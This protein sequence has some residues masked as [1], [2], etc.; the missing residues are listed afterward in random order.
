M[1]LFVNLLLWFFL[2]LSMLPLWLGQRS[3]S[4]KDVIVLCGIL[5]VALM[6]SA[7]SSQAAQMDVS[8]AVALTTVAPTA[9]STFTATPRPSST[10]TRLPTLTPTV[11]GTPLPMDTRHPLNS[12]TAILTATAVYTQTPTPAT[13]L[14]VTPTRAAIILRPTNTPATPAANSNPNGFTCVGGCT[15]QPDPSCAIKGNVNAKG[16]HIYHM[17]GGKNYALTRIKPVEGDRWFCTE[18]EAQDAGFRA[19]RSQ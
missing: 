11:T 13:Q 2:W 15:E 10:N 4:G 8:A 12:A 3:R 14:V 5:L 1:R 6:L 7:C 16:D 19:A 18:Q 17:P 9:Q